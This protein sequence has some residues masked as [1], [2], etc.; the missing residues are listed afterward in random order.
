MEA[1][2]IE[3][4][5]YVDDLLTGADD[6]LNLESI[7]K[8]INGISLRKWKFNSPL[9]N[10]TN[11]D[12]S[13]IND[14]YELESNTTEILGIVYNAI[15]DTFQFSFINMIITRNNFTK[16]EILSKTA[17]IFDPIGLLTPITIIPKLIIQALWKLKL[18]WDA[19]ILETLRKQWEDY[20]TRLSSIRDLK[21]N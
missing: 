20:Q 3:R 10:I 2:I 4:D 8:N 5:F 15:S 21:I 18:H 14:S 6:I 12:K 13:T 11:Q 1:E 17:Q 9:M 16:R 7:C 19:R